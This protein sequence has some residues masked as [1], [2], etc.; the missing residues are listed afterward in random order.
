[1][2]RREFISLLGG[3]SAWPLAVRAQQAE[4]VRFV[5]ILM[6]TAE[7]NQ[8]GRT[9]IAAFGQSLHAIGWME[10]RNIRI[11]RRWAGGD[12]DR[13]RRYA[14]ELVGLKPDVIFTF[15]NAQLRPLSYAT[16]RIPIVFVGASDP[17]GA[18]YAGSFARSGGNI[19]GFI[20]FEPS[21]AGKWMAML[22]EIAPAVSRAAI[23]VNPDTGMQ[24]GRFYVNEF[25]KAAAAVKVAATTSIVRSA[26]DIEQ[27]IAAL[28]QRRD[29]GLIVAPDGFIQAYDT[30]IVALTTQHRVPAI[31]GLGNFAKLGGLASY[32]PD[33]VDAAR[34][35]AGYVDRILKGEKP[36][37]LPVEAPTKYELAINLKTAKALGLDVPP[38]LLGRAD[39]VIE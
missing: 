13:A 12:V 36:A 23:M 6:D 4:R 32:G 38:T 1:M 24:Q 19:T 22:K 18:G 3:A 39:E 27:A 14:E 21:M 16:H 11:D 29:S 17:V 10:G 34:R 35:A 2:R 28:G 37:D 31:Y 8:E 7:S 5:G 33:L 9:R 15:G 30:F 25:E 20:L 26:H